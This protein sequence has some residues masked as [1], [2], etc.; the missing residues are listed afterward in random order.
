M[1]GWRLRVLKFRVQ[2][3]GC[4]FRVWGFLGYNFQGLG[5]RV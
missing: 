3:V 4:K 2:G 1:K 5:V